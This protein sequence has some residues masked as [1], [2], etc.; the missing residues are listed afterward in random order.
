MELAL[1]TSREAA[2][3]VIIDPTNPNTLYIPRAGDAEGFRGH[4]LMGVCSQMVC[5]KR[6]RGRLELEPGQA[7]VI[8]HPART[9]FWVGIL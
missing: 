1:P 8:P 3:V 5:D 2:G 6:G 7:G 4:H 9:L